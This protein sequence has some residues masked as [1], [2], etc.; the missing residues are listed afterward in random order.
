MVVVIP[1]VV[2]TTGASVTFSG[3]AANFCDYDVTSHCGLVVLYIVVLIVFG[4]HYKI[5]DQYGVGVSS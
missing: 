3:I 2:V 5:N 4:F 1:L